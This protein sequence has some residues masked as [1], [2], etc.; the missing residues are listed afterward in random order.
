MSM[1]LTIGRR[2]L[3]EQRGK[4]VGMIATL[5]A[6]ERVRMTVMDDPN[7]NYA[8]RLHIGDDCILYG[9]EAVRYVGSYVGIVRSRMRANEYAQ[10]SAVPLV[11]GTRG[12]TR[13]PSDTSGRPSGDISA[14]LDKVER[15]AAASRQRA[16]VQP[17]SDIDQYGPSFNPLDWAPPRRV[18]MTVPSMEAGGDH[19]PGLSFIPRTINALPNFKHDYLDARGRYATHWG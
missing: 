8:V 14:V 1:T 19:A 6:D 4:L 15:A 5:P 17:M 11:P 10:R 3:P 7:T 13:D 18:Y 9:D 12:I 16:I 2:L